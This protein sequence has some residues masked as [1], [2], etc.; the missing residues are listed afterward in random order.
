MLVPSENVPKAHT[1]FNRIDIPQSYLNYKKML[2][3]LM[4]DVEETYGFAVE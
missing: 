2:D 4:Q 3:K 1:C